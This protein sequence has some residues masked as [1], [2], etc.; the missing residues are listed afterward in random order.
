[1]IEPKELT[2][3]EC[4]NDSFKIAIDDDYYSLLYE[5]IKCGYISSH[6][7]DVR[8]IHNSTSKEIYK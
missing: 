8:S 7:F 6:W 1:M 4:G 3:C 5:C 2:L